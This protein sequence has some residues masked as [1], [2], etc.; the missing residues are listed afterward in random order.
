M[1]LSS[2]KTNLTSYETTQEVEVGVVSIELI[3]AFTGV[4][5]YAS[6]V[7][8]ACIHNLTHTISI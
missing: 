8:V 5:E 1:K 7:I 2:S 3:I 6:N 4:V